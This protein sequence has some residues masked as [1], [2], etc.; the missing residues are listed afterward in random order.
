M[1]EEIPLRF[2]RNRLSTHA[3]LSCRGI[4]TLKP[5]TYR[6]VSLFLQIRLSIFNYRR[7]YFISF[8][9]NSDF[10]TSD[11]KRDLSHALMS[12]FGSHYS[13]NG[14]HVTAYKG[15]WKQLANFTQRSQVKTRRGLIF[16]AQR[17]K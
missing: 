13:Y 5:K 10:A 17:L 1:L 15:I 12:L 9:Y 6:K 2:S 3:I 11:F 7:W 16:V 14:L 4:N 8:L